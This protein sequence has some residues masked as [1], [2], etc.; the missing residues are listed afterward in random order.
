MHG[1]GSI[2]L[3]MS[4][5]YRSLSVVLHMYSMCPKKCPKGK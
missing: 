5:L 4:G 3:A 1:T 2:G